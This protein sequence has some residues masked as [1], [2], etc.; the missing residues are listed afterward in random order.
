MLPNVA[1]QM[2]TAFSNIVANTGS[3]SP[4]DELTGCYEPDAYRPKTA[5]GVS[6][7]TAITAASVWRN[8]KPF[9]VVSGSQFRPDPPIS[10]ESR[11]WAADFNELKDYGGKTSR[12]RTDQQ[13]AN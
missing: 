1:S 7:P 3:K 6:V 11:E 2:R 13:T 8:M 10:L 4:S 12:K 9:A 5:A